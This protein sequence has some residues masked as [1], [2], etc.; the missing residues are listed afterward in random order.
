MLRIISEL[1]SSENKRIE[2]VFDEEGSKPY[3]RKYIL[4]EDC[5]AVY[6]KIMGIHHKNLPVIYSVGL[7]DGSTC[8]LE[9]FVYGE[10]L[11]E[12]LEHRKKWKEL[13]TDKEAA[14]IGIQLCEAL[15]ELHR[16]N[17]KIVHRDMKPGNIIIGDNGQIKLMDFD[18]ARV[19]KPEQANDTK[20]LGTMGYASPEHFGYGQ[21]DAK[22]D[23][24][25]VGVLLHELVTGET[26]QGNRNIAKSRMRR[27]INKCTRLEKKKRYRN[28]L[29]LKEDLRLLSCRFPLLEKNKKVFAAGLVGVTAL[30]FSLPYMYPVVQRIIEEQRAWPDLKKMA[31]ENDSAWV[32]YSDE[33][34]QAELMKLLGADYDWVKECISLISADYYSNE[35]GFYYFQ[36]GVRGLYTIMEAAVCVHQDG[37]I[38]CAYI[39]D[40]DVYYKSTKEL[41]D[42][43]VSMLDWLAQYE[44]LGIVVDE[45]T[46]D[47]SGTYYDLDGIRAIRVWKTGDNEYMASGYID[48]GAHVGG[49]EGTLEEICKQ[50]YRYR[51]EPDKGDS[52]ELILTFVGN[53]LVVK[54]KNGE[55]GGVGGEMSGRSYRKN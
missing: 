40:D 21:T 23:I 28:V 20:L 52:P 18:I 36:G 25:S 8:I 37:N 2:L 43:N 3:V 49:F 53:A 42:I 12:Q 35:E 34:V 6:L 5:V 32:I 26:M 14:E 9:E 10:T 47:F 29:E 33:K 4:N 1:Y 51:M 22:S 44:Y 30:C 39:K 55:I 24:Y 11:E 27:I 54:S 31:D 50:K 48:S 45:P 38:E 15:E 17:P 19:V 46:I 41:N 16:Q 7:E 13:Y